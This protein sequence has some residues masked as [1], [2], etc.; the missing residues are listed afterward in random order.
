MLDAV[1]NHAMNLRRPDRA[2]ADGCP[3]AQGQVETMRCQERQDSQNR[4]GLYTP[5]SNRISW[6]SGMHSAPRTKGAT[7]AAFGPPFKDLNGT[8][9]T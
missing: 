4:L 7:M 3:I 6:G 1:E 5:H 8:L 2:E 9:E